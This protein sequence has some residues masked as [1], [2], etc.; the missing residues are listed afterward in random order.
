MVGEARSR[1]RANDALLKLIGH[2]IV[3][4]RK[5]DPRMILSGAYGL[6]AMSQI[7]LLGIWK[8]ALLTLFKFPTQTEF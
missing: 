5:K 3:A 4:L 2:C 7:Q 1:S 6:S 8:N